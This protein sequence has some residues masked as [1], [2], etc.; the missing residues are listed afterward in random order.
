MRPNKR[1]NAQQRLDTY[2]EALDST[3]KTFVE[4]SYSETKS[5]GFENNKRSKSQG[6]L[7]L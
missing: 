2:R 7:D 6:F 5:A 4:N 3:L 1:R